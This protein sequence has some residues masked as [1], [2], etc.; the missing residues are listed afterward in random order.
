MFEED[1]HHSGGRAVSPGDPSAPQSWEDA[2][3]PRWSGQLRLV[4]WDAAVK[5]FDL[6][7]AKV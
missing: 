4:T 3:D 6:Q 2:Q 5:P 7:N 1:T